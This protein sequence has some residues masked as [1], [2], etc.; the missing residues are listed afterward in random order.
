VRKSRCDIKLP[1][2]LLG[3]DR[4]LV[5]R[6]AGL[7]LR[8]YLIAIFLLF[9]TRTSSLGAHGGSLTRWNPEEL[10]IGLSCGAAPGRKSLKVYYPFLGCLLTL[11]QIRRVSLFTNTTDRERTVSS[12]VCGWVTV[13]WEKLLAI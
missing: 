10:L 1:V 5:G 2:L 3:F 11:I 7:V 9:D 13:V 6:G 12:C 8:L 4:D